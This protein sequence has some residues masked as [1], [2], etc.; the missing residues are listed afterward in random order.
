MTSRL[1][2]T[3]RSP[4][5]S[6]AHASMY[7]LSQASSPPA[8]ASATLT[9]LGGGSWVRVGVRKEVGQG[10]APRGDSPVA[11]A[12]HVGGAPRPTYPGCE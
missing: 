5:M 11:T 2:R 3:V 6:G 7:S 1:K 10:S 9:A 8:A 12:P 4:R